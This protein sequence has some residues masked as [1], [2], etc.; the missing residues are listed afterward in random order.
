MHWEGEAYEESTSTHYGSGSFESN[1][2][3]D[4]LDHSLP[5]ANPTTAEPAISRPPQFQPKK[6]HIVL[7][8][9][10]TKPSEIEG[11]GP[12]CAMSPRGRG[13]DCKKDRA[14]EE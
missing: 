13:R 9:V 10:T 14:R 3:H 4:P 1:L 5:T 6:R 12:T 7:G 2:A 8:F 11:P